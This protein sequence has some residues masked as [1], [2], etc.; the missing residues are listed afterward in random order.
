MSNDFQVNGM[1]EGQVAVGGLDNVNNEWH[2]ARC[3]AQAPAADDYG[4]VV[5]TVPG[6]GETPSPSPASVGWIPF[7]ATANLN[8]TGFQVKGTAGK[9]GFLK[10]YNPDTTHSVYVNMYNA[11]TKTGTPT[12]QEVPPQSMMDAYFGT[13]GIQFSTG[14][15]LTFSSDA[16]A[17]VAPA[18]TLDLVS[19]GYI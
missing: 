7:S 15:F 10:V 6:S 18:T 1:A 8:L 17:S 19:G 9:I 5:R 2:T 12:S 13:E 16:G 3:I 11:A 4:L 14:I